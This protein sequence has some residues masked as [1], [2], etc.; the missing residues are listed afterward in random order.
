[1]GGG[2]GLT[3]GRLA[4]KVDGGAI[5]GAVAGCGLETA[6]LDVWLSDLDSIAVMLGD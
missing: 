4:V 2:C 6:S 1:M 5:V 3:V